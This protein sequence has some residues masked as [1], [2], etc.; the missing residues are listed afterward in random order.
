VLQ[1]SKTAD[2]YDCVLALFLALR[3]QS[4]SVEGVQPTDEVESIVAKG[5]VPALSVGVARNGRIRWE[6]GFGW[7]DVEN[8][9]PATEMTPYF[10]ASV[11]K[12]ITATAVVQLH[13]RG[14]LQLDRAVNDYLG[15]VNVHSPEW[16]PMQATVRRLLGH[17]SGLTTFARWCRPDEPECATEESIRKYGILVWPPGE[18]FD[19]SNLGYGILSQV[20]ERDTGRTLDAYLRNA[21]FIPLGMRHCV[22]NPGRSLNAIAAAQYDEK[23][24]R[25]LP[26]KIS[27][28]PGAT[29]LYCSAHDLL[30]LMFHLKDG[31]GAPPSLPNSAID[32]M[33]QPQSNTRGRYG[34]GWWIKDLGRYRMLFAQGGTSGSYASLM[35]VPSEDLA[36]VV[37]ANSYS[38]SVSKLG[39]RILARL[40]SGFT[41]GAD[42]SKQTSKD[43][44]APS[45]LV[46]RWSG[47]IATFKGAVPASLEIRPDGSALGQIGSRAPEPMA[48][49]SLRPTHFYGQLSGDSSI[50]DTPNGP[51]TMELDLALYGDNLMGGATSRPPPGEDGNQLPHWIKLSRQ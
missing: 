23:T 26:A 43:V 51:Y 15:N 29:G 25:R 22:V 4:A 14:K 28:H 16:N 31:W 45:A 42:E 36:V 33:H 50:P 2:V 49:I 6:K 3:I 8:R 17:M 12:S 27:S 11:T 37:L 38:N 20:I 34:L 24:H 18:V 40:L 47:Q 39:D 44:A 41:S 13:R 35:L 10:I 46:G 1:S 5:D 32:E 19:Y 30:L 9:V 21:L 48:S 7:A